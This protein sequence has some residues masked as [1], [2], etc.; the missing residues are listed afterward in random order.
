MSSSLIMSIGLNLYK[1]V[2]GKSNK[3]Q[4]K[5]AKST[6]RCMEGM[7]RKDIPKEN[8]EPA[9]NGTLC[10]NGRSW[11]PCYGDLRTVIMHEKLRDKIHSD[12]IPFP[13]RYLGLHQQTRWPLVFSLD[14]STCQAIANMVA[15]VGIILETNIASSCPS[16]L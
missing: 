13:L 11:L 8:L 7:I 12:I 2:L 10:L 16:N 4:E 15:D 9:Q 3:R 6:R 5:P 14:L 1:Q